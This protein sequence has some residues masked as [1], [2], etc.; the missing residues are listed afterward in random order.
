[1][2]KTELFF[3]FE[4]VPKGRPRH[5]R[6]G[7]DYTPDKTRKYENKIASYY[8]ENCNDYYDSAIKISLVFNM[9]IPKSASKKN[10]MLMATGMIKCIKHNGDADNLAKSV[11]DALNGVAFE[12]DCL[13]TKLSIIKKYASD[14]NVGIEMVI[15]EDVN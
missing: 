14:N 3:P 13:V 4:P 7:H 6:F 15:S 2:Q 1:M 12:D 9:P 5:T 10:K 8:R 11:L